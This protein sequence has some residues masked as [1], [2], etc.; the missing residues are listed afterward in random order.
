ML[1]AAASQWGLS[2]FL[3]CSSIYPLCRQSGNDIQFDE[4]KL[5]TSHQNALNQACQKRPANI[6]TCWPLNTQNNIILGDHT[7]KHKSTGNYS[8]CSQ[9]SHIKFQ[10]DLL[11]R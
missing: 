7:T 5:C 6:R 2:R 8:I 4:T 1:Q 9:Y 3:V 11:T 10:Y